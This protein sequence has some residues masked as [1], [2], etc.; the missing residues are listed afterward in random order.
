MT[1]RALLLASA[2]AVALPHHE[3]KAF[4]LQHG[5]GGGGG[6]GGSPTQQGTLTLSNT[7]A[8]TQASG[9]VT[10]IFSWIFTEG[11][12]PAGSAP[13]FLIASTPQPYS[14]GMQSYWPDGSLLRA[15]FMLRCTSSVAGSGT[16]AI[17]VWNGGTAPAASARTLGEVWANGISV[18]FAGIT[19]A[20]GN[21][22][23]S[24]GAWLS[25]SGNTAAGSNNVRQ[26]LVM[27]GAAG[28]VWE[29]EVDC[30]ATQGGA[31][32]GQLSS[33][34][35]IQSLT[36]GSGNLAGFRHLYRLEQPWWDVNSPAKNWCAFIGLSVSWTGGAGGTIAAPW[37]FTTAT[38]TWSS[39]VSTIGSNNYYTGAADPHDGN[40]NR[41]TIPGYLTGVSGVSGVD[42]NTLYFLTINGTNSDAWLGA[43]AQ[44]ALAASALG[45]GSGTATF[46]PCQVCLSLGSTWGANNQGKYN[47]FQGTGSFA[48]DCTIRTEFDQTYWRSVGILP[49]NTSLNGTINDSAWGASYLYSSITLGPLVQDRGDTG[50]ATIQGIGYITADAARYFYTQ[51][52]VSELTVRAIAYCSNYDLNCF[53]TNANRQY[54][55][56]TNTT[57]SG[58]GAPSSTQQHLFWLSSSVSAFNLTAPPANNTCFSWAQSNP[59]HKPAYSFPA[60]LYWGEPQ[61]LR[62]MIEEAH[63]DLLTFAGGGTQN[64]RNPTSPVSAAGYGICTTYYGSGESRPLGWSLRD[65]AAAAAFI[66]Q[67][68]WDGSS[69]GQYFFDRLSAS[70]AFAAAWLANNQNTYCQSVGMWM[71]GSDPTS[72][73]PGEF[74]QRSPFMLSYQ[75]PGN[76]LA[77]LTKGDTNAYKCLQN[78]A[79]WRNH[80]LSTFGGWVNYSEYDHSIARVNSSNISLF[81]IKDDAHFASSCAALFHTLSWVASSTTFTLAS[82]T[83][84]YV[85]TNGDKFIFDAQETIPGSIVGDAP[86]IAMNVSGNTIQLSPMTTSNL[87]AASAAFSPGDI[88]LP[89]AG[90]N[91][92]GYVYCCTTTAGG[93]AGSTQ[94][95]WPQS[96]GGT[97]TDNTLTWQNI[98]IP[99][100]AIAPTTTGSVTTESGT[101]VGGSG[102]WIVAAFAQPASAGY[103]FQP[104]SDMTP[105]P[106]TYLDLSWGTTNMMNQFAGF[107]DNNGTTLAAL[108]NDAS[109][110]WN[111]WATN[112]G[113]SHA[114]DPSWAFG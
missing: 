50:S 99:G 101:A 3:A 90:V 4:F 75:M 24:W 17:G 9:F 93:T 45:T 77:A 56:L 112:A 58:M 64:N 73:S 110:R 81:Q 49:F 40:F 29:M 65:L 48:A 104:A 14:W 55:N 63:Y 15:S 92:G 16:L 1:R 67:P 111:W 35:W 42:G 41:N 85:P 31:A 5:G 100:T 61:Y 7:S 97:V 30:S 23:G 11:A 18:N 107:V 83:S 106:Q 70:T 8:S 86:Y 87:W 37:P 6:G 54:P 78:E 44:G 27:D 74:V 39:S 96:I 114:T 13:Q 98:G 69:L 91:A 10:P 46:N 84:G 32:H 94:P 109:T 80:V 21:L 51:S 60:F 102:P 38:L 20:G 113:T 103:A 72:S 12:I 88:I 26:S 108:L 19:P 52:V 76:Y 28:R 34:H 89:P 68:F 62:L 95:T 59:T 22:S 2:A 43:K 25:N 82:V 105:G 57:Y 47:F 33:M 71:P 79:T 36:D 66:P 53:R